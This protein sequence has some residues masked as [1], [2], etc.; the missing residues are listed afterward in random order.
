MKKDI[1]LLDD[2]F[3]SEISECKSEEDYVRRLEEDYKK[4][5]SILHSN[6]EKRIKIINEIRLNKIKEIDAEYEKSKLG[7]EKIREKMDSILHIYCNKKGHMDILISRRFLGLTGLHSFSDGFERY[8]DESYKCAVCGRTRNCNAIDYGFQKCQ[9]YEKIIPDDIYDGKFLSSDGKSYRVLQEDF[10]KLTQYINYLHLLK[11][12]LC[13]LF[14]HDATMINE[15]ED[16]KCKCCGKIMSHREYINSHHKAK[17]KGIVKYCYSYLSESVY[18]ISF[19]GEDDL[20]LPTFENYQNSLEL[21]QNQTVG[22]EEKDK[23]KKI[24]K[25]IKP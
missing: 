19:I 20:S 13:E 1:Y 4:A 2:K 10:L 8:Y 15:F 25:R 11:S 5:L 23:P 12:K 6:N 14:G 16:F 21:D 9:K 22:Q 24:T 7:L 3:S 17:Y 18:I